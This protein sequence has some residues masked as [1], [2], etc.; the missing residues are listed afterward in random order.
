[1]ASSFF[2]FFFLFALPNVRKKDPGKSSDLKSIVKSSFFPS[3]SIF[4]F[5]SLLMILND[6]FWDVECS[7]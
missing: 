2:N 3:Q 4:F 6:L 5:I 7:S 1:M